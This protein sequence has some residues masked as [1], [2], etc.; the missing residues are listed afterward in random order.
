MR[1]VRYKPL[2]RPSCYQ[3]DESFVNKSHLGAHT[4]SFHKK[5]SRNGSAVF[6][7]TPSI[8]DS[9][10][11]DLSIHNSENEVQLEEICSIERHVCSKC[12]ECLGQRKS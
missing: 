4:K 3:C 9:S 12:I 11:M 7:S 8:D 6:T 2:V 10:L 1:S 5:H